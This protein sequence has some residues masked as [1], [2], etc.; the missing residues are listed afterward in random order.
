MKSIT[1]TTL[2]LRIIVALALASSIAA[3]HHV[4]ITPNQ[5]VRAV[6]NAKNS[7]SAM[8]IQTMRTSPSTASSSSPYSRKLN[9]WNL[10]SFVG[11]AACKIK[12]PLRPKHC[13]DHEGDGS[14]GGGSGSGSGSSSSSGGSGSGGTT[15]SSATD[16]SNGGTGSDGNGGSGSGNGGNAA[17][18]I[19]KFM[20]SQHGQVLGGI[21]G[22]MAASV[23]IAAMWMG[24]KNKRSEKKHNLHGMLKKRMSSFSRM[25]NR[26]N[27]A[28]CRPEKL[29]S[30]IIESDTEYTLA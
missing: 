20:Q 23:A 27:C 8:S 14:G 1:S 25:A 15:T 30:Q 19:G 12:G 10:F 4:N 22:A 18:K 6:A 13:H 2:T 24:S 29:D 21:L 5:G 16:G 3:Q 11:E 28:T 7:N 26:G 17:S 9:I